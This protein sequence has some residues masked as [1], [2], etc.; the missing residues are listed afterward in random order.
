MSFDLFKLYWD[1]TQVGCCVKT[2]GSIELGATPI[3]ITVRETPGETTGHASITPYPLVMKLE[4]GDAIHYSKE[5]LQWD[6]DHRQYLFQVGQ[7]VTSLQTDRQWLSDQLKGANELSEARLHL[8]EAY[9]DKVEELESSGVMRSLARSKAGRAV[10]KLVPSRLKRKI[11]VAIDRS[12][13]S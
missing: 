13:E 12:R 3:K 8:I 7:F 5:V 9:E 10:A 1:P 6:V 4:A 2:G 11:L